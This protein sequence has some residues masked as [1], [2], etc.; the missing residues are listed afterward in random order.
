M[1]GKLN[2]RSLKKYALL[3]RISQL[4]LSAVTVDAAYI[5]WSVQQMCD[6]VPLT[7]ERYHSVPIMTEHVLAAVVIYLVCMVLIYKVSKS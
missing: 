5:Y 7:L 2:E 1:Y 4:I 6:N 3:S